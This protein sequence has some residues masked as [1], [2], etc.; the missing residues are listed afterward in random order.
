M[1][2]IPVVSLGG[3]M[4]LVVKKSDLRKKKLEKKKIMS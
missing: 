2:D 3:S 4:D 1:L